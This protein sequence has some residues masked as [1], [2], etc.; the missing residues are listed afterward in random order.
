MFIPA[1]RDCLRSSVLN[2]SADVYVGCLQQLRYC[3]LTIQAYLHGIEHFAGWATRRRILLRSFDESLM[4]QFVAE[5][6]P[7]CRC[8]DPCQLS[9]PAVGPALARLFHVL[10]EQGHLSG[11][12]TLLPPAVQ[13]E[14]KRFD[15]H[16]NSVCGFSPATRTSRR[17]W[18]GT[19]LRY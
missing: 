19:L 6:L 16:L 12:L 13:G 11:P 3:P 1:Y 10:R 15:H 5:H 4:H 18:V 14:L 2:Q 8:L 9:V 17:R 7:I